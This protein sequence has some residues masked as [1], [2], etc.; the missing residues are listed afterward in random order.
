MTPPRRMSLPLTLVLA[1]A[2]AL[3]TSSSFA[4]RG[5]VSGGGRS[6]GGA[7]SSSSSRGSSVQRSGGGG[8]S[9]QHSSPVQRSGPSS[10]GSSSRG[11]SS[12][13]VRHE[14]PTVRYEAPTVRYD[15]PR[16]Q[17][18]GGSGDGRS[19]APYVAP[20]AGPSARVYEDSARETSG[21]GQTRGLPD[22]SRTPSNESAR[23]G[24]RV[25]RPEP[26]ID[27]Y[28]AGV[29]QRV[30]VPVIYGSQGTPRPGPAAV[31]GSALARSGAGP[32]ADLAPE[33][34]GYSRP[35]TRE[36]ILE[37]YRAVSSQGGQRA[38]TQQADGPSSLRRA[39]ANLPST[40]AA[41]ERGFAAALERAAREGEARSAGGGRGS[42]G[43]PKLRTSDVA[44]RGEQLRAASERDPAA[45][46][47]LRARG[48]A[49]A[50]A[51][52]SA[53]RVGVS[54]GFG[55]FGVGYGCFW[56][57]CW[58][59]DPYYGW[60]GPSTWWWWG[61]CWGYPWYPW[62]YCGYGF[63]YGWGSC[64]WYSPYGSCWWPYGGYYSYVL[65][66]DDE[67]DVVIY[68]EA[69][70]DAAPAQQ[71][72]AVGEGFV[73]AAPP[74]EGGQ[75][76]VSRDAEALG[77][78]ASHYLT[79]GDRAFRDGRYGDAVH[80]YAKA[81]EYAPDDGVLY[82]ILA[83]ALF[84]TGDF[85]Y[86]AYALRRGIELDGTLLDSVVDKHSFYT[87]PGE[88][89]RQLALAEQYLRDHFLDDDARLVLAANYLFAGR[90]REAVDLL[91]SAFSSEVRA[92][93]AGARVLERAKAL[94]R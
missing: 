91:E 12:P 43:S 59:G 54:V 52:E 1:T 67:P 76:Q 49:V 47:E 81:V 40:T 11:H 9:V 78:A 85:H 53:I 61:S 51:T 79:L 30:R 57:P 26:V 75:P 92:S 22:G 94:V 48:E 2:V 17:P 87:D 7:S 42:I 37:R 93:P 45:G 60:C 36:S 28:D 88:F 14:A 34:R 63:S 64:G 82:L 32:I 41:P 25:W 39:R 13:S 89:D 44:R 46:R 66:D 50:R 35:V 18:S 70:A 24:E 27:L 90:P 20:Y 10:G 80:F 68:E 19:N 29:P 62:G 8:G 84:A 21:A 5:S 55:T 58:T 77:R 3:G 56:D 73:E 83:D 65:Y 6:S 15:A 16:G 74:A 38:A 31:R 4:Q 33:T 86:A 23:E 69:P 72:V 71:P